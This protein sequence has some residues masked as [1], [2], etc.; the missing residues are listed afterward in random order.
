MNG[1]TSLICAIRESI[2]KVST[3]EK[4]HIEATVSS[5]ILEDCHHTIEPYFG[6]FENV[7]IEVWHV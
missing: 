6:T 1:Y 7:F 4:P 3:S 2:D 5:G